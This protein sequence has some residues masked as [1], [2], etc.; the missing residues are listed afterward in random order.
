LFDLIRAHAVERRIESLPESLPTATL[1]ALS[2]FVGSEQAE[3]L[4]ARPV[5]VR[6]SR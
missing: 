6:T 1:I 3:Q 2:P 5:E 4:A